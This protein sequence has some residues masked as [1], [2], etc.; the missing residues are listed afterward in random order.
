M[1]HRV[2]L[3]GLKM[4][5]GFVDV[6]NELPDTCVAALCDTD[7]ELLQ[8]IGTKTGISQCYQEF[9]DM[10]GSADID[11]VVL[12]TP[13]QVHGP[14]AIAAL[15][16]GKHVLC[17]YIAANDP[18]EAAK[19]IDAAA[20]SGKKYMTIETDCYE[21]RN[22]VMSAL[23]KQGVFGEL[24]MGRGYYVHDTKELTR[25]SDGNLTWRG[26]L[27]NK[28]LSGPSPAVHTSLP[29]LQVFGERV[30]EVYSYGPGPRTLP[31]FKMSD[32]IT[33]VAKLESG[34]FVDFVFDVSSWRP[35]KFGYE[36]QGTEGYFDI[37]HAGIVKDGKLSDAKDLDTLIAEFELSEV[38]VDSGGHQSSWT[39]IIGKFVKAVDNNTDP[40]QDLWDALH[41]T[42]IGW[43]ANES[44]MSGQP[45]QV[46]QFGAGYSCS[47]SHTGQS[48]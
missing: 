20:G 16:A 38:I 11:M 41:M 18:G 35:H 45:A 37:D 33:T 48:S 42:A 23:A 4:A 6:F 26:H 3:V 47:R 44:M 12:A 5:H 25:D 13:I 8:E 24:T 7:S 40:P 14:H 15:Q 32:R 29:L 36:L 27:R 31:E 10:I 34:R 43:A 2:G 21:R 1:A 30:T 9:D 22:M 39:A 46:M 19:L 28:S 17:Q